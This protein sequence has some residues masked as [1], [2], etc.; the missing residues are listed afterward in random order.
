MKRTWI[1]LAVC[2]ALFL[3]GC[4]IRGDAPPNQPAPADMG[5][6][7]TLSRSA[8]QPEPDGPAY[9]GQ[10]RVEDYV[11]GPVSALSEQ[12]A[13]D[14]LGQIV[15]YGSDSA[16]ALGETCAAPA[17]SAGT[18]S[19]QDFY[20]S[21]QGQLTFWDIWLSGEEAGKI[22]VDGASFFG[23][24]F[25]LRDEDSL[26]IPWEGAFFLARRTG[27][28]LDESAVIQE[29]SFYTQLNGWEKVRFVSCRT[30]EGD[31]AFLLA[32]DGEIVYTFPA[33][34]RSQE[35]PGIFDSVGALAFQDVDGDGQTDVIIIVN[36][37]SGTGPQEMV[38]RGALRIYRGDGG[39]FALDGGL[40]DR[41]AAF[42]GTDSP[43]LGDVYR[44]FGLS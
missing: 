41:A 43:T 2:A 16:C 26:V 6:G 12:D 22:T 28:E 1:L 38:S 36:Y 18:V 27:R 19:A 15:R 31:V 13:Q 30:A 17:Y 11:W 42:A 39:R 21:F 34:D 3:A 32:Q 5:A 44:C 23:G 37:L 25:Y 40:M 24:A 20:D 4:G 8:D 35:G 10:W 33:A 29:R 14:L 7:P 9:F